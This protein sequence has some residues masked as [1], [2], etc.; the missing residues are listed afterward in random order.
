MAKEIHSPFP[1]YQ[2]NIHVVTSHLPNSEK[3]TS[4]RWTLTV[5]LAEISS[6]SRRPNTLTRAGWN[7]I[8]SS[9]SITYTYTSTDIQHIIIFTM[10]PLFFSPSCEEHMKI[11]STQKNHGFFNNLVFYINM[12]W[13]GVPFIIPILYRIITSMYIQ[14]WATR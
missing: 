9:L 13:D 12:V 4:Q 10:A 14:N 3:C 11:C 2:K 6:E 8:L 5:S 7:S 1:S